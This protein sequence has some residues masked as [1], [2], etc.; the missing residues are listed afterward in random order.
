ME[1]QGRLEKVGEGRKAGGVSYELKIQGHFARPGVVKNGRGTVTFPARYS[2]ATK[3]AQPEMIEVES[4]GEQNE[5]MDFRMVRGIQCSQ[6]AAKAGTNERGGRAV[7]KALDDLELPGD[8]QV[9]EIALGQ[10]RD[11]ELK[12]SRTKPGR[13]KLA[14]SRGRAG[15]EAMQIEDT[16]PIRQHLMLAAG[17][18]TRLELA[19]RA[20]DG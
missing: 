11:F 18:F 19:R 13:K 9:L 8:G 4:R 1:E 16:Q 3:A 20:W 5:A 14:L 12:A 2:F 10:I 17:L 15:G 6:I 7:K